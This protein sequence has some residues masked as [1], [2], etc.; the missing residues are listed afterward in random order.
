[1]KK[2]LLGMALAAAA[3]SASAQ[4]IKLGLKIGPTLSSVV[5]KDSDPA[6]YRVGLNGGVTANFAFTELLSFQ[7]E[8]LYSL[9]GYRY[10]LNP[11][12]G[13]V[14]HHYVDVPLLVRLDADGP[15][16]ELGP[17]LGFLVKATQE[18]DN[19]PAF[20]RTNDYKQTDVGGIVGV[21]YQADNGLSLGLR[22]NAGFTDLI[23]GS[24][25]NSGNVIRNS[26]FQLQL[27][28]RMGL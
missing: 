7:P 16:F 13:D 18:P 26:A 22:Y 20:E 11:I 2:F 9:K 8:V 24:G 12:E 19:A 4:D 17:Q 14:R 25:G 1:M 10:E 15:F 23:K 28:Y 6:R 5:G 21:G 3:G 27:G